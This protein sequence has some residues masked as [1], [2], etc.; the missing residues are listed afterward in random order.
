MVRHV[1]TFD[2]DVGV[3][4]TH[5]RRLEESKLVQLLDGEELGSP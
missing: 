3:H 1:I 4:E 2:E 5:Y